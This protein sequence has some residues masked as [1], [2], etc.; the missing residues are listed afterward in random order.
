MKL[1]IHPDIKGKPV[2][3]ER[4]YF[5]GE[6]QVNLGYGWMNVE[7]EWNDVFELVTTDGYATSSELSSDNRKD[8][9]FVS[10]QLIM[11]DIDDG[12]TIPDLLNN[13]FYNE[14]GAGFYTTARHTD[15]NHRFRIMFVTEEPITDNQLMK[16]LIK[17]LL[18]VFQSA[19][20]SCKDASRLYY[21]IPNC[22]IK[23]NLGKILSKDMMI[24]LVV[25]VDAMDNE[26]A[27]KYVNTFEPTSVDEVFVDELLNR[28]SRRLGNLRGDYNQW[29]T[30]A[31]ATCHSVG[32]ST[33][34]NLLMKHWYEKTK[35]EKHALKSWRSSESPT[36]GTLIKLS[37]IS[38]E[39]R[40]LLE[41]QAQLRKMK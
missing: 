2:Q 28:I 36:I 17:G 26:E 25:M 8:E 37:G 3:N 24:E 35:K 10:R 31:W 7:A 20:I 30:I 34:T 23:E 1:S 19:D 12:M 15:D 33:A 9:N 18:V 32:V 38:S 5:I 11:V 13:E 16:K 21:G 41:L 14:Y 40:K 27:K 29:L 39:E 22:K 4:G 6:K